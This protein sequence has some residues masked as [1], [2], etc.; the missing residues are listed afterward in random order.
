M[1]WRKGTFEKE[2]WTGRQH[3]VTGY[4]SERWGVN[5]NDDGVW[6][7]THLRLKYH[8]GLYRTR[9]QAKRATI[10]MDALVGRCRTA[11]G[12]WRKRVA[13]WAIIEKYGGTD[14]NP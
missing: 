5:R 12:A 10:P 6:P 4:V 14:G 8:A 13:G 11:S 2:D 3:I 7:L 9:E 1:I